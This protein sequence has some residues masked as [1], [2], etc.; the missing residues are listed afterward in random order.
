[1]TTTTKL[2]EGLAARAQS[3]QDKRRKSMSGA[4]QAYH[5]LAARAARE[6]L[7]PSDTPAKVG[8]ILTK[9][10]SDAAK[11]ARA[12]KFHKQ[13]VVDVQTLAEGGDLNRQFREA[14]VLHDRAAEAVVEAR[15][16]EQAA[17]TASAA[18]SQKSMW[19]AEAEARLRGCNCGEAWARFEAVQAELNEC[20]A[21][22]TKVCQARS[23]AVDAGGRLLVKIEEAE[24]LDLS[25]KNLAA[26]LKDLQAAEEAFAALTLELFKD[27]PSVPPP[28]E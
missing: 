15:R 12:V 4:L 24:Q 21:R 6:E 25:D 26:T 17:R 3:Q 11:F 22:H 20:S 18:V 27:G 7:L 8:E 2:L 14:N 16:L 28:V 5:A 10:N 1:M 9:A 23:S 19:I 13:F